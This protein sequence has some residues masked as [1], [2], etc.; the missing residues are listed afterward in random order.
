MMA[1]PTLQFAAQLG[2]GFV[3]GLIIGVV[4]FASLHWNARLFAA[5][6]AGKA[7]A[8]Q[9]GRIAVVVATLL[10][11]VLV[12]PFASLLGAVGFSLARARLLRPFGAQP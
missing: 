3:V 2:A 6:S 11:L 10:L 1:D 7:V 12:S 9:L 8:L 5:G 4:H